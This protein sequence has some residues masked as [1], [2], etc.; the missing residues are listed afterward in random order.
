[1]YAA[2]LHTIAVFKRGGNDTLEIIQL[3]NNDHLEVRGIF[4]V[5][6]LAI[7]PDGRYLYGLNENDQSALLFV[8][9]GIT[10]EIR[11]S[12][13]IVDSGFGRRGSGIMPAF[14][15]NAKL[16]MASDGRSLYRL[17]SG[18]GILAVFARDLDTGGL[19]RVQILRNGD[20]ELG[21]FNIPYWI[22]ASPDGRHI[23]AGGGNGT[24]ILILSR[25]SNGRITYKNYFDIG[26]L[27]GGRWS[28]GSITVSPR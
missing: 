3:F 11:L 28:S 21:Y 20:A 7:S 14:E 27:E 19:T 17:S 4:N 22:A 6:D 12:E 16:L 8:R 25:N 18:N 1:M 5:T 15:Q 2:G 24:Q 9:D 10:G 23:Y 13:V 26:P